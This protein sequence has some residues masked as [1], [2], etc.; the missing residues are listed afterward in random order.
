MA[1]SFEVPPGMGR[2]L[3]VR[4]FKRHP[5][6]YCSPVFAEPILSMSEIEDRVEILKREKANLSDIRQTCGPNGGIMPIR[7]QKASN[8]CWYH[9]TCNGHMILRGK[10]GLP[11]IDLSAFSGAVQIKRGRNEG[12]WC[13]ESVAWARE[14]GTATSDFWPQNSFDLRNVTP[15]MKANARENRLTEIE[16]GEPGNKMLF[17]TALALQMPVVSDF[18]K[19]MHSML[20]MEIVSLK[21]FRIRGLN[22]WQD[23]WG[24]FGN[25]EF[26]E[27]SMPDNWMVLRV[28][29]A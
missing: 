27:D 5:V 17:L 10:A 24:P 20:T 2:G 28:P 7:K 4:D 11:Y 29:T 14:H 22:S 26:L 18:N 1:D 13:Q 8:Y 21:P 9:S 3:V 6:G 15:E 19:L 25:G 12:G 16:D 23:D